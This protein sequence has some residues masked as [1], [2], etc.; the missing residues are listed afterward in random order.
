MNSI[1]P[2]HLTGAALLV[3]RG[4]QPLLVAPAGELVVRVRH[5]VADVAVLKSEDWLTAPAVLPAVSYRDNKLRDNVASS[6][7]W[8]A[9]AQAVTATASS[10]AVGN[11]DGVG[12]VNPGEASQ[13]SSHRNK[14]ELLNRLD[15]KVRGQVQRPRTPLAQLV[16]HRRRL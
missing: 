2:L 8:A 12:K 6:L 11:Q 15:Q 10:E 16:S 1:K 14:L 3:S 13:A 7:R 9:Q 5:E 4:I